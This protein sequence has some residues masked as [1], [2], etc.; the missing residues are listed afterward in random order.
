MLRSLLLAFNLLLCSLG[1]CPSTTSPG[2]AEACAELGVAAQMLLASWPWA[3]AT[4]WGDICISPSPWGPWLA[5]KLQ[6]CP[7]HK[8]HRGNCCPPRG[9][10]A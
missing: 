6:H 7:L 4:G 9:Q 8:S 5:G 1:V 10:Q 2:H 3:R